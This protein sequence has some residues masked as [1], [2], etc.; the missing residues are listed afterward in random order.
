[1]I[2]KNEKLNLARPDDYG[3]ASLYLGA[4]G[5]DYFS[6]ARPGSDRRFNNDL[7]CEGASDRSHTRG[8]DG[9]GIVSCEVSVVDRGNILCAALPRFRR[10]GQYSMADEKSVIYKFQ[11]RTVIRQEG[12]HFDY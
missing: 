6:M 2:K 7:V 3:V 10:G 4:A 11:S 8:I 12:I 1:M 9:G 5:G